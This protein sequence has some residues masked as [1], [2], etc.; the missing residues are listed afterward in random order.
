[1]HRA[2]DR[3]FAGRPCCPPAPGSTADPSARDLPPAAPRGLAECGSRTDAVLL[4]PLL[5][6]PSGAD[7]PV[8]TRKAAFR[9]RREL[10]ITG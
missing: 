4:V 1:M 6:H 9:L 7:R 3:R 10:G 5:G 8:H 2:Y